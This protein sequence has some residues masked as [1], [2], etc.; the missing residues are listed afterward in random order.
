MSDKSHLDKIAKKIFSKALEDDLCGELLETLF[1]G[2]SCTID[3]QGNLVM[4]PPAVIEQMSL[5]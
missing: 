3:P 1:D 2:G 5:S 4:I